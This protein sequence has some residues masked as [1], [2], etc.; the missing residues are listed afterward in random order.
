MSDDVRMSDA[1]YVSIPLKNLI[2][3]IVAI[4]SG[5]YAY[6]TI[7]QRLQILENTSTNL[8]EDIEVNSTWIDNWESS[9]VLPLD[10]EQNLFIE[11][12]KEDVKDLRLEM[13]EI[14]KELNKKE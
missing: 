12:L 7:N 9:G 8:E 3:L 5:L 11:R 13:K 4:C 10:K 6:F 2:G 14:K 1:S